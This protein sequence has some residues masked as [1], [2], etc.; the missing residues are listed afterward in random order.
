MCSILK[1][2][3]RPASLILGPMLPNCVYWTV[4]SRQQIPLQL[5]WDAGTGFELHSL[6]AFLFLTLQPEGFHGSPTVY[7]IRAVSWS[8]LYRTSNWCFKQKAKQKKIW[9]PAHGLSFQRIVCVSIPD[10]CRFELPL[11]FLLELGWTLVFQHPLLVTILSK[12]SLLKKNGFCFELWFVT[13]LILHLGICWRATPRL[14]YLLA[15]HAF[16]LH[17]S[18]GIISARQLARLTKSIKQGEGRV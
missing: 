5:H 16:L 10:C 1:L 6:Q 14:Q 7:R 2:N 18:P 13:D 17:W 12:N 3:E 11:N 4:F 8:Y 15:C 9:T